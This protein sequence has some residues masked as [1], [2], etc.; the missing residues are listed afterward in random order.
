M[1]EG[2][3]SEAANLA[4]EARSCAGDA[5]ALS[6]MINREVLDIRE[7]LPSDGDPERGRFLRFMAD[8]YCDR[9]K[10][11]YAAIN[12]EPKVAQAAPSGWGLGDE[13]LRLWGLAQALRWLVTVDKGLTGKPSE[14][15]TYAIQCLADQVA[16]NAT[17]LAQDLE[18]C[19]AA[20]TRLN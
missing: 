1:V 12:R 13:A 11:L 2:R 20:R 17:G 19:P 4:L 8:R 14:Q 16:N 6:E 10:G 3:P 18:H 7:G 15:D 9:L 5:H